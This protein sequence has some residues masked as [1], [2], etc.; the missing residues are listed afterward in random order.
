ILAIGRKHLFNP[1]AFAV[2]LTY[3]TVNQSAS[4]WVG[5]GPMLPLVLLGG[6]LV[7]RKL[8]RFD[9]VLSFL[10]AAAGAS[11]A[12]SLWTGQDL[13]AQLQ[14]LLLYSPLIFF[15]AI[16]VTEPLTTPPTRP[17]RVAYGALVGFLFSPQVHFGPL[18]FTPE[19]AV[20]AGNVFS[21]LVSPKL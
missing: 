14:S 1:A 16:I 4:W 3:V 20:L 2:A 5:S 17:L 18:Y 21:Y 6:G 19:L 15:A 7:V 11:L 12:I 8:R 13:F 10:A 9:L